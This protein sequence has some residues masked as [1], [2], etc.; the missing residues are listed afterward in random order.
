MKKIGLALLILFS[1]TGCGTLTKIPL[2]AAPLS[3]NN[4]T[5]IIFH[6]Q[7][8][9]DK[10]KVYVDGE[11]KG[12]VTKKQPLKFEVTPG[13]HELHSRTA[14]VIDRILKQNFVAGQTYFMVL[15]AEIGVWVSSIWIEPAAPRD[16][17]EVK[18]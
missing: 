12:I 15:R 13:E 3:R 11:Q 9:S 17:Y 6:E 5:V 10:F 7:G 8:Y 18:I 4:S 2:D 1:F 16:S 14:L